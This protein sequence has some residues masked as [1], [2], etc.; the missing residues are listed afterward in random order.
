MYHNLKPI[1]QN[2]KKKITTF[3]N[4]FQKN[5]QEIFHAFYLNI[6]KEEIV[7]LMLKKLDNVS[8][9]I[10]FV[11]RPTSEFNDQFIIIFTGNG[12]PRLFAKMMALE[13]QAPTL[14]YFTA[15]AFIKPLE[16]TAMYKDGTDDPYIS[17]NFEIKISEIQMALLD[18][19]ITKK[20]IKIDLYLPDYNELKQ[21]DD[22]ESTIE[23]IVLQI[24]GEIAFRKHMREINLYPM[25]LEPKGL[26]PLIELPDFIDYLYEI[27][28]RKKTRQI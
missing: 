25:P 3:W 26:L 19:D 15:Q 9:S 2:S 22:L 11:I 16:N 5:E 7:A 20:Q 6:K 10:G 23:Y 18:Y 12:L 27:N 24:I 13:N 1:T 21:Y 8:K 28:S 14:E 4:W 17:K